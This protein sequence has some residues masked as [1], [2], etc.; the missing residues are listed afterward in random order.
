MVE[1]AKKVGLTWEKNL[2]KEKLEDRDPKAVNA[3]EEHP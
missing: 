1:T 2:E 3:H